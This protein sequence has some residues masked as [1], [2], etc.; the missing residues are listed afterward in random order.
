MCLQKLDACDGSSGA[1]LAY[2][3][4]WGGEKERSG[5]T[6]KGK[7]FLQGAEEL[8]WSLTALPWCPGTHVF[9][10][11]IRGSLVFS[12]SGCLWLC[13][14]LA[15]CLKL[16]AFEVSPWTVERNCF[17]EEQLNERHIGVYKTEDWMH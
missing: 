2:T 16:L 4:E 7:L 11:V 3:Q 17:L 5:C 6:W 13:H 10:V 14:L 1:S 12:F 15:I 8:E 9:S